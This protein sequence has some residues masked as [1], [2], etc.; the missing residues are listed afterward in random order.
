MTDLGFDA[1]VARLRAAGCVFAEDEATLL[2]AEGATSA[3]LETMLAER[4]SGVPLEHVLGWAEF[5][6]MRIPVDRGVFVPRP[7]TQ[8]LVSL[9][10]DA[11]TPGAVVLDLCCGSGAIGIAVTRDLEAQ[12]IATD[13][14][15]AAVANARRNLEPLGGIV[16]RGDLYDAVPADLEG[17]VS[18]ITLIAPYVPTAAIDLLPHEA[19]DFEPPIALDGG[20]D[21]LEIVRR[22]ITQA[23]RWLAPGGA[24]FTEV[25]EAQ[26]AAT[27]A[28]IEATGLRADV[29]ADEDADAWV[30]VASR[31]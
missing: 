14:D 8:L 3:D 19:R 26:V 22:A 17:R 30:V 16:V 28:H 18:V 29:V 4:E 24:L 9:A 25:S 7:R 10:R 27:M 12:L 11:V 5:C 31:S 15:E 1:V 20:V 23:P 21:G 6:G 13:I 2:L